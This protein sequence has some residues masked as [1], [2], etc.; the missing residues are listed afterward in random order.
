[1]LK[2]EVSLPVALAVGTM[3]YAV[4]NNATPTIADL[5]SAPPNDATIE[6]SRMTA[7]WTSA[8]IVAFVSIVAKDPN[9]FIIGGAAVVAMDFWTRHS[10][11]VNP[12]TQRAAS[13][14]SLA[15]QGVSTGAYDVDD[16][17][18]DYYEF[19]GVGV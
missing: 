14:E 1:M 9:I 8:A 6:A 16:T 10:N 12:E 11:A 3:V 17:P 4:H 5:R 18:I 15:A 19:G 7:T 13:S 2:P